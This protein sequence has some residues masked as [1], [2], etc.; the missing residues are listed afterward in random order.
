LPPHNLLRLSPSLP[1]RF[2]LGTGSSMARTM[3]GCPLRPFR[4]RSRTGGLLRAVTFG[5]A[6]NGSGCLPTTSECSS[7]RAG[8]RLMRS[9]LGRFGSV[10]PRRCDPCLRTCAVAVDRLRRAM[11][12]RLG[13]P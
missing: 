8:R 10:T 9:S 11:S 12:R 13:S 5:A 7:P 3:S 2:Y 6:E 4:A 1:T